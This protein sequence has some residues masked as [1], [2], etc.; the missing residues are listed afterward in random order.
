[1]KNKNNTHSSTKIY[2][3]SIIFIRNSGH[4]RKCRYLK[5]WKEGKDADRVEMSTWPCYTQKNPDKMTAAFLP[6]IHEQENTRT[7]L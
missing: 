6:E 2:N 3:G 7:L 1:M 4:R 5:F